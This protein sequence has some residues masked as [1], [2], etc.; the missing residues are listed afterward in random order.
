MLC[1]VLVGAPIGVSQ[2]AWIQ[3]SQ[4]RVT[5]TSKVLANIK[6]L[7]LSGMSGPIFALVQSL[8]SQELEI[9][10]RFRFLLGIASTLCKFAHLSTK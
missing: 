2:G 1:G 8:R 6:P 9:S 3:A 10:R 7:R 5:L 4:K